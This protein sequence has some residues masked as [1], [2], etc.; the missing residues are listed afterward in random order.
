VARKNGNG[1]GSRPRKR[2]DGRW[3]ARYWSEAGRRSVYGR[4][5]KEV[6]ER[7]AKALAAAAEPPEFVPVNITL[8]EFL[9]QYEDVVRD[10]MKRRSFE[11]YLDIA[12]LHLLPAFGTRSSRA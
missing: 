11:T 5:R 4:T 3:E 7:L 2:T 6:A 9:A 12:R 8:G 10:T 1:E